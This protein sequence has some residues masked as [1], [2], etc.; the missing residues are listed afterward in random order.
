MN[1]AGAAWVERVGIALLHSLWQGSLVGAGL[2]VM[3]ILLRGAGL[4]LVISSRAPRS[5]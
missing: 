5:P 1:L 2:L 4:R 3:L